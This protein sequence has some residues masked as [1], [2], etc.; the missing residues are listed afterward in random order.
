[1]YAIKN[2]KGK[3]IEGSM[4]HDMISAIHEGAWEDQ[5]LYD[6]VFRNGLVDDEAIRKRVKRAGY[7]VVPV[8]VIEVRNKV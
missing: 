6:V 8:R 1:M 4:S 5:N 3:L 7:K 2:Q